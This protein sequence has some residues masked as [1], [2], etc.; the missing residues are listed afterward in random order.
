MIYPLL[1][2][3]CWGSNLVPPVVLLGNFI[4]IFAEYVER[5]WSSKDI[6]TA[7]AAVTMAIPM[8]VML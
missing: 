1:V 8:H 7:F 5:S 3:V 6:A 4:F 2:L